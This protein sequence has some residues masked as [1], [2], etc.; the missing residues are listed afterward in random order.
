MSTLTKVPFSLTPLTFKLWLF[1]VVT[2]LAHLFIGYQIADRLGLFIGFIMAVAMNCLV[3]F[4]GESQLLKRLRCQKLEGQDSWGLQTRAALFAKKAGIPN[5]TI[6]I[7]NHKTP[8]AFSTGHAWR[9]AA[10]CVSTGLLKKLSEEELNAVIAHQVSHI[11]KVDTFGF[12][13]SS[14]IANSFVGMAQVLDRLLPT[15]WISSNWKQRPFM[16]LL[17]PLAWLIIRLVAK[18]KSFFEAD[19]LAVSLLGDRKVLAN[20]LWKLES[21]A[22][23]APLD[24]P[25]CTSHLFIVNPEGLKET[26][27]F[28]LLHPKMETRLRR[29]VG[30]YPL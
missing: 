5:P 12:G 9:N 3:F 16:N 13:A 28:F 6:Y 25:P 23:T 7:M 15:N 26:N 21:Y 10:I 30:Y 17:S 14:T 20:T 1:V 24:V 11:V 8:A 18:D 19:D 27:W 4:F 22:Q 2:A 29:M